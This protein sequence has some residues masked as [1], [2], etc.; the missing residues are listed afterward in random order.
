MRVRAAQWGSVD[1]SI[2]SE[3]ERYRRVMR[4]RGKAEA[5]R[6]S[7]KIG[8]NTYLLRDTCVWPHRPDDGPIETYAFEL[9][10]TA[11]WY[12]CDDAIA[13][14]D[15][16]FANSVVTKDRWKAL[17][18]GR[19]G[20]HFDLF[21]PD[22]G[23][24]GQA[25]CHVGHGAL[26]FICNM[27]FA[28]NG[29]LHA[30]DM[31][32]SLDAHTICT[33]DGRLLLPPMGRLKFGVTGALRA[34][35]KPVQERNR[36]IEAL[37]AVARPY[38][39]EVAPFDALGMVVTHSGKLHGRE[40]PLVE[41]FKLLAQ[42]KYRQAEKRLAYGEVRAGHVDARNPE[43]LFLMGRSLGAIR[44]LLKS[45]EAGAF[46]RELM[47][48]YVVD[49]ACVAHQVPLIVGEPVRSPLRRYVDELLANTRQEEPAL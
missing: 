16:N 21:V 28:K 31:P 49:D 41:G 12:L 27:P 24:A 8:H 23:G 2:A 46:D 7:R 4:R 10:S 36:I 26:G 37:R 48:R 30:G 25:S 6:E 3:L 11:L 44:Y 14:S 17:G 32:R 22:S 43:S 33:A 40:Q 29:G 9:H 15:F 18:V 35:E 47:L 20:Q 5:F 34:A 38:C 42:G 13:S 39:D 1:G 45:I 19:W